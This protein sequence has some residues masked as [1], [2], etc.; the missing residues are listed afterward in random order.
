MKR[1]RLDDPLLDE[2]AAAEVIKADL[3]GKADMGI[4]TIKDEDLTHPWTVAD[5]AAQGDAA[6][7]A[8]LARPR[9]SLHAEAQAC[10]TTDRARHD[11]LIHKAWLISRRKD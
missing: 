7:E 8:E 6:F 4:R 5:R 3:M 1:N 2:G 10:F 11:R 9:N